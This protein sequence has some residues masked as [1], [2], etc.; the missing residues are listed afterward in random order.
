ME[1]RLGAV[2]G[3]LWVQICWVR[4]FQ[5]EQS[6][7]VLSLQ[8]GTGSTLRC[9]FSAAIKYVQW[10]RQNPGGSLINLFFVA[11]GAKQNGRVEATVNSKDLYS[12]LHIT[13]SHLEDS[14][15]YLC[16]AEAQCPQVTCRLSSNCSRAPATGK[17]AQQ[18]LL[19]FELSGV[20]R[21]EN[22]EQRPSTLR[23]LEGDSSVIN[24]SYSDSASSYFP[25]YKQE[26]GKGP[27][28]IIDIRENRDKNHNQRLTVFL[29]KT[30]K[31][32][33]LHIAATQPG[34]AAV[35]FCAASAQCFPGTCC[36]HPNPRLQLKPR[37]CP[38]YRSSNAAF[39]IV[40]LY[41]WKLT[42]GQ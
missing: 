5:V 16:A 8:E 31:L 23:V 39:V 6:P 2:L 37:P 25:W 36:L 24:C 35:Y 15:T 13:A 22:V 1:G 21:G 27:Q 11:S 38:L 3:L 18:Q 17:T 28:L 26:P 32:F 4:G 14:G 40:F 41:K 34:D 20:S 12:T 29:D 19:S 30:E 7:S 10:F 33:S 9:N 42:H